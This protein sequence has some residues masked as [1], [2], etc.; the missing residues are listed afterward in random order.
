MMLMMVLMM[1][2]MMI[3]VMVTMMTIIS[4]SSSNI[5]IIIIIVIR[6]RNYP[7]KQ[8]MALPVEW[9]NKTAGSPDCVVS[10]VIASRL[11]YHH[12]MVA[13]TG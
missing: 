3:M 8:G 7:K 5:I 9:R 4:S 13:A 10:I 12:F 11:P 6:I 2:M 1:V